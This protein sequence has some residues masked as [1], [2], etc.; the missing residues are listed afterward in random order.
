MAEK[1]T[2]V[3]GIFKSVVEAERA[4]DQLLAAGFAN[5]DISVLLSDQRS[6]RDFAHEKNTKAPEGATTGMA[7]G[8]ALGGT[9][10]LLAGLGTLAIPGLGPFIAAGPIMAML[11]GMG[12]GGAIGG[13]LGALVGMGI[14]EYEAKRYEGRVKSGGVL[15]SVHCGTSEEINRAE[16]MLKGMGA[17]DVA[18]ASEKTGVNR[19]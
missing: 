8:G 5:G 18:S 2:S 7:A 3:F 4:A 9:L 11:G 15:L 17:E 12:A 10:G 16:Q 6:T 13:L 1:N 19:A 14:P